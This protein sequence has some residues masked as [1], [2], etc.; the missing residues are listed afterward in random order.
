MDFMLAHVMLQREILRAK[1]HPPSGAGGVDGCEP[2]CR[3]APG[4]GA[5]RDTPTPSLLAGLLAGLRKRAG[6]PPPKKEK[7]CAGKAAGC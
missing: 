5:R 6:P 1:R 3:A 2:G 4:A 7:A